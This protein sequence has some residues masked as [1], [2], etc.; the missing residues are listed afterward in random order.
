[1]CVLAPDA[2]VLPH[3]ERVGERLLEA[4]ASAARLRFSG[5]LPEAERLEHIAV[6]ATASLAEAHRA[7]D[8]S[9]SLGHHTIALLRALEAACACEH[10][11]NPAIARNAAGC[12]REARRQ[13]ETALLMRARKERR[14]KEAGL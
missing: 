1:M 6:I 12:L 13:L 5:C 7:L 2:A 14:R 4:D 8:G 11:L 10:E 3:L 9:Y